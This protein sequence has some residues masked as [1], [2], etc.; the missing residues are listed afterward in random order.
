M[1]LKHSP[2]HSILVRWTAKAIAALLALFMGFAV[3]IFAMAYY[4]KEDA[5]W[6]AHHLNRLQPLFEE[7]PVL[8]L[9]GQFQP[10]R[11]AKVLPH[12]IND[13]IKNGSL[14]ITDEGRVILRITGLSTPSNKNN[15]PAPLTQVNLVLFPVD[16]TN[17]TAM[18]DLRRRPSTE[19]KLAWHC[20]WLSP[21]DRINHHAL[22]GGSLLPSGKKDLIRYLPPLC[23]NAPVAPRKR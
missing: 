10:Q 17:P 4:A 18:I 2:R 1:Y 22:L 5:L 15:T 16:T 21:N 13:W 14:L 3:L 23:I 9:A 11:L 6:V 7:I 12:P 19:K 20:A 8:W